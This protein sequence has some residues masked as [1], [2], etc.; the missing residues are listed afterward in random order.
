VIAQN[1]TRQFKPHFTNIVDIIVG[2]HIESHQGKDVKHHCS[3]AL[4]RNLS[5]DI[6]SSL[7]KF[8]RGETDRQ[9]LY[10][11]FGSFMGNWNISL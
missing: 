2:W 11:E 5:E 9:K 1:Y 4:L 6:D 8:E 10:K 3:V 7:Q